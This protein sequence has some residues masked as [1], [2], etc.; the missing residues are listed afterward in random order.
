MVTH[1]VAVAG[2]AL[3]SGLIHIDEI[4]KESDA[5]FGM[6]EAVGAA[7]ESS[8][9]RPS[10]SGIGGDALEFDDY[11]GVRSRSSSSSRRHTV[12]ERTKTFSE[13]MSLEIPDIKLSATQIPNYKGQ[14]INVNK[15][16]PPSRKNTIVRNV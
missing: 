10:V 2:D 9:Y 4:E 8:V 1:T 5:V 15:N 13:F 7:S 11:G 14:P 6:L 12:L 3:H 16:A